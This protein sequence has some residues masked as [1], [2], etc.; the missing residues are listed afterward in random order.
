MPT[1]D[2]CRKPRVALR[3]LPNASQLDS[4]E[5]VVDAYIRD[6][7]E[8]AQR[9]RQF[10]KECGSLHKAIEFAALCKLPDGKRHPHQYRIPRRA[11]AEAEAALQECADE[12]RGCEAFHELDRLVRRE[13][14]AIAG[15]GDLTVYDVATRIGAH[16]DLAPEVVYL[17]AGA[18][19]GAASLGFR[20]RGTVN[21]QELPR[22]FGRLR[23]YEVED[24]LCI[25]KRQLAEISRVDRGVII[26]SCSPAKNPRRECGP[27]R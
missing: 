10:F 17:H 20:G 19:K 23:A 1:L 21:P 6:C 15:V 13:I 22:A 4:Y 3:C 7:R 11:L 16:L 12:L 14:G 5:A 2:T 18:A 26:T 25:Y 8:A 24:C 27:A 9:E